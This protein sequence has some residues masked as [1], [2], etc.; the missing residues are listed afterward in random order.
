MA[1]R[2]FWDVDTQFDFMRAAGKLYVPRAETIIDRLASLTRYAREHGIVRVASVCDHVLSDPEISPNPD[3]LTTFPPHCLHGTRGQR[4]I[5]ATAMRSPAVIPNRPIGPTT[6][7]RRIA[8]SKNI[9]VKKSLFDVFSNPNVPALLD[10]LRPTTIVVYGVATDVC[11]AFAIQGFLA[12]GGIDVAFVAD[13]AKPIHAD[14]G[15]KFVEDWRSSGVK[16]VRTA[17][18]LAGK[19]R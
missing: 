11:D 9:L 17:D 3:F 19:V 13:A 10:E 2:V 16:V 7:R 4:K 5:A 6:L 1:T 15:R 12:R 18:V 14:R 8:G